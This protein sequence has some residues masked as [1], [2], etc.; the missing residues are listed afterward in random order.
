MAT[1]GEVMSMLIPSGGWVVK[2]ESFE[3]IEF[4][5]CD[6]ITKKQFE[7]GFKKFESWKEA[8]EAAAQAKKEAILN[9][10]GLT[11]DEAKLLL[12]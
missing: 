5:E 2:G 9:K 4:L 1:A 12:S 3:D 10:L 6:P 8:N 11:E 7:D